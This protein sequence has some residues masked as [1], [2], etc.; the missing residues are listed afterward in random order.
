MQPLSQGEGTPRK[1]AMV[2]AE[3]EEN[4]YGTAYDY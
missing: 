4:Q 3:N 2:A 1:A